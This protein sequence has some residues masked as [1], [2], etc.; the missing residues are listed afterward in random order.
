M[1]INFLQISNILSF[2]YYPDISDAPKIEFNKD[3]NILIGQ[4]G[5]GKSTVLEVIN[6]IFKKVLFPPFD[7]NRDF[8]GKRLNISD[9]QRK[10]IFSKADNKKYE[11]FR[12]EPNWEAG[13]NEQKIK[14]EIEL[15]EIDKTNLKNLAINKDKLSGLI[16]SYASVVT[17]E[18]NISQMKF[19]IEITLN[20][21]DKTYSTN[22]SPGDFY[23]EYIYLLNYKL[24]KELIDLYNSERSEE[25]IAP[26]YETFS[27]IGSY[28]NY[29]SFVPS[30]SLA[31]G[32]AA[33]IQMQNLKDSERS[34]ST[35]TSEQSEPTI[36]SLVRLRMAKVCQDAIVTNLTQIECEELANNQ[37]FIEA[38][39]HKLKIVNLKIEIKLID[40]SN[41]SYRFSFVDIKRNKKLE[42][43][44]S[45]SAGQKAIVHLVFE[46]YGRGVLRGGLV[47]I[48]EPEIHLHYQFQNEYLCII[49]EINK[50]QNC[51]YILV[52]HSESLINSDTISKIKRFSLDKSSFT[53]VKSPDLTLDQKTLIKI[54]DN[55]NS[56][57]AFFARKVLL[58]EGETDQY[59]F[60]A[61][62]RELK[63]E[64]TQEIAIL[65]IGGKGSYKKWKE[66]FEAFG[67]E[68]YYV[69][70]FDNVDTLGLLEKG[71]IEEELKQNKLDN[72]S[73]AQK[74]EFQTAYSNLIADPEFLISPKRKLWKP[75]LDMFL[76]FVKISNED[77]VLKI[78]KSNPGID[79]K[80]DKKKADGIYILKLGSIEEYIKTTHGDLNEVIDF[81]EKKLLDW[82]AK[83]SVEDVEIKSIINQISI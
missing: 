77:K 11:G 82:L 56:T 52:T 32:K 36:F 35:N 67:L 6:F 74:D 40:L 51:Q 45:L 30:V 66:L 72:L 41:W 62:F 33:S 64:L 46:A 69:C 61:I 58:V 80:I 14:I 71:S 2:K 17:N 16:S 28:R 26:L 29:H 9:D 78:K 1:K 81:C 44:N 70:D 73:D 39:N 7:F 18:F 37:E 55:T 59:F 54:L 49:K 34:K 75:L 38:I 5:S 31:G 13:S 48:D 10:Q 8:Y 42:D 68:V 63:P 19:T 50:E 76:G 83:N 47:I 65:N 79:K 20:K 57:F 15:D 21:V 3:L 22:V 27:L 23:A 60:K 12:L 24:Y 25:Q 43:I 53:Q 4:N